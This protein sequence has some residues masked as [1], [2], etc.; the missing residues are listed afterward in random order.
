MLRKPL[1]TQTSIKTIAM[2]KTS[3]ISPPRKKKQRKW[4]NLQPPLY[5]VEMPLLLLLLMIKLIIVQ[6]VLIL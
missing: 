3:S 6:R 1:P 5:K 2:I 4:K